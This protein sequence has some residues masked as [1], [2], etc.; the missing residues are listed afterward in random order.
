MLE[1]IRMSGEIAKMNSLERPHAVVEQPLPPQERPLM[2]VEQPQP[3]KERPHV[4]VEQPQPP[5]PYS[6]ERPH[7]VLQQPPPYS[8]RL[9][10]QFRERA[11]GHKR[12]SRENN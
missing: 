8:E 11:H 3:H 4:M 7:V 10:E 1:H 9:G 5:P 6:D 12:Q 2:V